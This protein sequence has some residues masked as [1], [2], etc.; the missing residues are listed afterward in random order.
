[1]QAT[2]DEHLINSLSSWENINPGLIEAKLELSCAKV[3]LNFVSLL[4]QLMY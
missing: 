4:R 3:R 2:Y 1:M